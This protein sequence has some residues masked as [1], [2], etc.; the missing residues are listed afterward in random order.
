[1]ADFLDAIV[2]FPTVVFTVLAGASLTFWIVSTLLGAGFDA[3]DD[4][5]ETDTD[6][7]GEGGGIFADV[8]AF[9]GLASLPLIV[10]L[11][12]SSLFAWLISLTLMTIIGARTTWVI[13]AVGIIVLFVATIAALW[14]TSLFAKPL[15]RIFV[16][17]PAQKRADFIGRECVVRTEKV[18]AD[19][20]QAE[21]TDTEGATLLVQVRCDTANDL[22]Y[23][24]EGVLWALDDEGGDAG[25]YQITPA[26]LER[27][28]T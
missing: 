4:V 2:E 18:T 27:E 19:F 15:A 25:V 6:V 26:N 3:V 7:D 17:E 11:T 10:S 23:G 20:G 13:V 8:L 14:I 9:F 1:M 16:S 21:V 24:S 5:F 12:I 28:S 22:T